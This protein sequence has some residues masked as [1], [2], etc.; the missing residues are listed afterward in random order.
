[1][2]T[3]RERNQRKRTPR[4]PKRT[5]SPKQRRRSSGSAPARS[6]APARGRM[7][8]R[9]ALRALGRLVEDPERTDQVFELI[10][11][12]TGNSIVRAFRKFAAHPEGQRILRD[13]PDLV[14]VLAD[15]ERLAAMPRGSLGRTYLAFMGGEQL[16]ADGLR[17]AH[18]KVRDRAAESDVDEPLRYF[19]E[20]LRDQHDLWHVLTGYGRDEAGEVAVLSFTLAQ[21]R[22]PGVALIVAAACW[23]GPWGNAFAWQRYL[24]SAFLRGWRA[25]R[26]PVTYWEE[27][28]AEPLDAVRR[29]LRVAPPGEAH[30]GGVWVFE[31]A[32][33]TYR[34]SEA[35]A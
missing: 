21:T 28:L 24:G 18:E 9:R 32:T 35:A 29:R 19:A 22:N 33:E 20:R 34:R 6:A 27:L 8:W 10:Q 13:R 23:L 15:R 12:L 17:V 30:P 1:M 7:E 25:E 5:A 31:K 11:A 2:A 16:S 4:R 26:L 14:A 3:T